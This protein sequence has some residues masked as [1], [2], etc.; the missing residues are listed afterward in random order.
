MLRKEAAR[1]LSPPVLAITNSPT[2][3]FARLGEMLSESRSPGCPTVP[4]LSQCLA[5]R[6]KLYQMYEEQNDEHRRTHV[7]VVKIDGLGTLAREEIQIMVD[8][9]ENERIAIQVKEEKKWLEKLQEKV[10]T[11]KDC[12][13]L[14][15]NAKTFIEVLSNGA[16]TDIA[17]GTQVESLTT[18]VNDRWLNEDAIKC[19]FEM[20]NRHSETDAF[21]VLTE[22]EITRVDRARAEVRQ[23]STSSTINVYHL[24]LNV[25]QSNGTVTVGRGNHWTYLTFDRNLDVTRSFMEIPWHGLYRQTFSR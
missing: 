15:D 14:Y 7:P 12:D 24:A 21:L 20:M 22:Q 5:L 1:Q 18:L 2:F 8:M 23:V 17:C 25:K 9:H 6:A 16:R 19:S 3:V 10:K 11:W 13:G 4:P